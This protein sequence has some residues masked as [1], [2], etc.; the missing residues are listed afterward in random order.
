MELEYKTTIK[1]KVLWLKGGCESRAPPAQP[2]LPQTQPHLETPV[3]SNPTDI[4]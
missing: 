2:P 4:H 1:F 3:L